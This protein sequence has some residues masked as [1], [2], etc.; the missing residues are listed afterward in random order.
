M[1]AGVFLRPLREVFRIGT[2]EC[3]RCLIGAHYYNQPCTALLQL[4][5]E[6]RACQRHFLVIIHN[7]YARQIM[8][9][10]PSKPVSRIIRQ[11]PLCLD[12]KVGTVNIE[13]PTGLVQAAYCSSIL[14]AQGECHRPCIPQTEVRAVPC[15][16][17]D[18]VLKPMP[19]PNFIHTGKH[20]A[21]LINEPVAQL[22]VKKRLR[23]LSCRCHPMRLMCLVCRSRLFMRTVLIRTFPEEIHKLHACCALSRLTAPGVLLMPVKYPV[24]QRILVCRIQIIGRSLPTFCAY[25]CKH[26]ES[27]CV[28]CLR[29][30]RFCRDLYCVQQA[31]VICL[32]LPGS[33]GYKGNSISQP[34]GNGYP[35]VPCAHF[36]RTPGPLPGC[37]PAA[38]SRSGRS[39]VRGSGCPQGMDCGIYGKGRFPRTRRTEN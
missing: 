19:R 32:C 18:A 23:G 34:R 33:R 17:E 10:S 24:E 5:E 28:D 16:A 3:L 11:R 15:K 21:Q 38:G 22:T 8:P 25:S 14:A 27:Q 12:E 9:D 39:P 4:L 7:N 20:G 30:T 29:N 31:V 37:T 13:F 1:T 6:C 36:A 2:A 26:L 35:A